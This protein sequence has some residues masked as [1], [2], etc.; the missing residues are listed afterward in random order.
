MS[1]KMIMAGNDAMFRK[2]QRGVR[3][4]DVRKEAQRMR[5]RGSTTRS[6]DQLI[7]VHL[8][9][10]HR[11]ARQQWSGIEPLEDLQQVASVGLVKAAD[12]YDEQRAA[13]FVSYA[14]PKINGELWRYLRDCLGTVRIPRPLQELQGRLRTMQQRSASPGESPGVPDL[15]AWVEDEE[16]KVLE[17][18]AADR[19]RFPV[20]LQ[21][22]SGPNGTLLGDYIGTHDDDIDA[23]EKRHTAYALLGCL[24]EAERRVVQL[25]VMYE[26]PQRTVAQRL[27]VS[28]MQVSR[29]RASG[30][31]RLRQQA[32]DL[33]TLA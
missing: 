9:L 21:Q 1:I 23:V 19:V 17:A 33:A 2:E 13:C 24:P 5:Q 16:K 7:I 25:T 15:A 11:L 18:L 3:K 26:L 32:G 28:Q 4:C 27:G 10:A 22:P 20:S 29:L 12:A 8:P 30:L 31:R 14:I 6:R